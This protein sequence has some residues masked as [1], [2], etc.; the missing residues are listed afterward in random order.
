MD[1]IT[2]IKDQQINNTNI[3]NELIKLN[4]TKP[5]QPSSSRIWSLDQS[6]QLNIH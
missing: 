5:I 1:S 4:K 3:I 6:Y 2:N